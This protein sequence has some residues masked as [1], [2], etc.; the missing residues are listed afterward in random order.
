MVHGKV[1]ANG[2]GLK[3]YTGGAGAGGTILLEGKTFSGTGS[4]AAN[5]EIGSRTSNGTKISGC[6]GGG[7][8]AVWT[9]K[10]WIEGKSRMKHCTVSETPVTGMTFSGTATA[11]GGIHP[12]SDKYNG[13]DGTVRYVWYDGAPGLLLFV[14]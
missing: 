12:Y 14:R 8:I 4:L 9:G 6:G 7:R 3:Q 5:G 1:T 13:K 11:A 2:G 10:S